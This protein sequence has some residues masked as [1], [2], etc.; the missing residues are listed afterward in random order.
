MINDTVDI[1]DPYIV[2]LGIDFVIKPVPGAHHNDVLRAAINAL[3]EAYKDGMFIGEAISISQAYSTL[4]KVEGILDVVKIKFNN[5][6]GGNYSAVTFN[7]NK[8]L[9]PEGDLLIAPQNA[10]FEVKYPTID[11]KGKVR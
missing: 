4:N 11:I 1:L 2:N 3:T 5:K 9:S 7:V 6:V 8:N 10:I